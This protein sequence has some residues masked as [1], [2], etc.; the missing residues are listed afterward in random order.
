M[1]VCYY[2]VI[3]IVCTCD[4][5]S[6]QKSRLLVF[7]FTSIV[8]WHPFLSNKKENAHWVQLCLDLSSLF[9]FQYNRVLTIMF[10]MVFASVMDDFQ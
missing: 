1:R 4:I 3:N 6:R 9:L 5:L 2:P 10:A 8:L 7:G